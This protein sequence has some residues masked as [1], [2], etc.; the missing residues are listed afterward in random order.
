MAEQGEQEVDVDG[1]VDLEVDDLD[2][3]RRPRRGGGVER[4]SQ[5][6]GHTVAAQ[7]SPPPRD[8]RATRQ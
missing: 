4:Q 1:Y 5:S 3:G 6:Q 2:L 8:P 7:R